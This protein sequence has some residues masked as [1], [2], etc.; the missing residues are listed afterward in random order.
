VADLVAGARRAMQISAGVH[1][2]V[3]S[4]AP[5]AA[6]VQHA[7]FDC[8]TST[9]AETLTDGRAAGRLRVTVQAVYFTGNR[10][11]LAEFFGLPKE[12]AARV[13]D[14]WVRARAGTSQYTSL[15]AGSL[16]ASIPATILPA[17]DS[18]T[19][20]STTAHGV[21]VYRLAWT[22]FIHN[23]STPIRET[24]DLAAAGD[25]APV[26]ETSTSAHSSQ[27]DLFTHWGSAPEVT[28]PPDTIPF[29]AAFSR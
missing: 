14:R 24:L 12:A 22:S 7:S 8:G 3:T 2:D 28:A 9:A 13:G 29:S 5:A 27:V 23:A 10:A 26:S 25:H 15:A 20:T 4:R 18:V 6:S 16:I 1:I 11:G 17:S 19:V 21:P